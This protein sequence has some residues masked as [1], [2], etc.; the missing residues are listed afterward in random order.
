MRFYHG[1]HKYYC[2]IDLH[3]RKNVRLYPRAS[4]YHKA[5]DT[6]PDTIF[7]LIIPYLEEVAVAA[8]CEFGRYCSLLCVTGTKSFYRSL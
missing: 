4:R 2:G 7:E 8:D 1:Q 3:A 5:L 6:N